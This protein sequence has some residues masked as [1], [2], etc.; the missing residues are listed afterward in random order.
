MS[1]LHLNAELAH[2]AE[3]GL[4]TYLEAAALLGLPLGSLYSMVHQRRIPH[5]RLGPRLV[6]FRRSEVEA[7][8]DSHAV[9]ARSE[10]GY[11]QKGP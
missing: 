3:Q 9:P 10:R 4:L 2:G 11:M 8:L 6:R 7:W 5:I 1:D